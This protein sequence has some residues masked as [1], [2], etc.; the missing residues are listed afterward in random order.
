MKLAGGLLLLIAAPAAAQWPGEGDIPAVAYPQLREVAARTED[1]VPEGWKLELEVSGDLNQD[2][3][4]DMA[5]VLHKDDPANRLQIWESDPENLY[6]TNPRVLLVVFGRP[7]GGFVRAVAEHRLITR[8]E[9]GNMEDPFDDLEIVKGTLRLKMHVFMTAGGWWMGNYQ[10]VFRWQNGAMR[11][12]GYD[13]NGVRRNTGETDRISINYLTRTK[14][15][16]TGN[17]DGS[18]VTSRR[19]KLP[20]KPLLDLAQV[21]DGLMF[22]PDQE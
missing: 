2:R 19:L 12:I 9:Q 8:L 5:L 10:F 1:F 20:K 18:T 6:D 21:G 22:D 7:E 4:A 17:I 14:L 11:L 15:V 13:R 3:I 16:E